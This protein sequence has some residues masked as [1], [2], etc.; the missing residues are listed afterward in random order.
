MMDF[1]D[2]YFCVLVVV[3]LMVARRWTRLK[4]AKIIFEFEKFVGGPSGGGGGWLGAYICI[5]F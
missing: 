3:E 5:L 1:I 4:R 2:T